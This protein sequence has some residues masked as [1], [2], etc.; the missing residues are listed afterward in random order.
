LRPPWVGRGGQAA[1]WSFSLLGR[2]RLLFK[3]DYCKT[4]IMP[5][6]IRVKPKR[7]RPATGR[8]P[9]VGIRLPQTML[10]TIEIYRVAEGLETRSE[11]IRRL[12]EQ[13]LAVG[14]GKRT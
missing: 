11:A 2:G 12:V 8:N 14:K 7:G 9:F 10:D 6:S 1:P 5:K 13:A 3:R 4:G